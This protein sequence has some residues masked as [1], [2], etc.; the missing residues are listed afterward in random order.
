[1][2]GRKLVKARVFTFSNIFSSFAKK[3][4]AA[5]LSDFTQIGK[6]RQI[7]LRFSNMK[8]DSLCNLLTNT[9]RRDEV[10]GQF[11]QCFVKRLK[12]RLCSF[13]YEFD[14]SFF[15]CSSIY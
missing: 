10:N 14:I 6:C 2:N 5:I 8:S 13:G 1:M 15:Y 7:L 9:E 4:V 3:E 12:V 11:L